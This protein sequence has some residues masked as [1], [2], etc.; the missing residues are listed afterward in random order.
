MT[1]RCAGP[2]VWPLGN[3]QGQGQDSRAA[4]ANIQAWSKP[5]RARGPG[6]PARL[7]G[8]L[9]RLVPTPALFRHHR[10]CPTVPAPSSPCDSVTCPAPPEVVPLFPLSHFPGPQWKPCWVERGMLTENLSILI[11]RPFTLFY[12][13]HPV[14][15]STVTSVPRWS[16]LPSITQLWRWTNPRCILPNIFSAQ[17]TLS[18]GLQGKPNVTNAVFISPKDMMRGSQKGRQAGGQSHRFRSL[19]AHRLHRAGAWP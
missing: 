12:S 18:D 1:F 13:V 19:I 17:I 10:Q 11:R 8:S 5:T 6:P 14:L 3:G 7:H 4:K 15:S 16:L 2:V 9:C